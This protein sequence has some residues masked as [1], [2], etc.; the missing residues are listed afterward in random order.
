MSGGG[1]VR[2]TIFITSMSCNKS[3]TSFSYRFFH[4]R[5]SAGF[6]LAFDAAE[7]MEN[8]GAFSV[9]KIKR[10]AAEE[11]ERIEYSSADGQ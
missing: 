7:I 1:D 6:R 2:L 9:I 11:R 5:R 4:F 10:A 8:L 3:F